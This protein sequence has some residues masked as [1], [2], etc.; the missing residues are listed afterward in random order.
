MRDTNYISFR[1]HLQSV[2][3]QPVIRL[4]RWGIIMSRFKGSTNAFFVGMTI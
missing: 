1:N 3:K 2:E 4:F